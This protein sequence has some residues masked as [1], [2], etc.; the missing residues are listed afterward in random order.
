MICQCENTFPPASSPKA[1]NPCFSCVR[2]SP[3]CW[4]SC[5]SVIYFSV[6]YLCLC[7]SHPSARGCLLR[8]NWCS[9]SAYWVDDGIVPRCD[10]SAGSFCLYHFQK[11]SKVHLS[12]PP[13]HQSPGGALCAS[14][15]PL[16]PS[17][18][19]GWKGAG[20]LLHLCNKRLVCAL[21]GCCQPLS[22]NIYRF[23]LY[24]FLHVCSV[25]FIGG[26]NCK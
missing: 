6:F 17:R 9:N 19:A 2:R 18:F 23:L 13:T 16:F 7:L 3:V 8:C 14:E 26:R 5:A 21:C 24:S 10:C 15:H 11:S 22:I 12:L 4:R 1:K 25:L 20:L